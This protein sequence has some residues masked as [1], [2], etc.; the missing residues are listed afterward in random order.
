MQQ[1]PAGRTHA[2]PAILNLTKPIVSC[3]PLTLGFPAALT[4]VPYFPPPKPPPIIYHS[5]QQ[6]DPSGVTSGP[7][8][9]S[10]E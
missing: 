9:N 3:E 7:P 5:N 10:P 6:A 1:Y 4:S 8:K 2:S